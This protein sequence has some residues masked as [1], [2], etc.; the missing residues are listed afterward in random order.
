M[1]NLAYSI[2]VSKTVESKFENTKKLHA[3][4]LIK[5]EKI[6][7]KVNTYLF[8][9]P[10]RFFRPKWNAIIRQSCLGSSAGFCLPRA[11]TQYIKKL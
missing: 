8:T 2:G 9:A 6:G 3:V 7:S 1:Q 10:V 11:N 4:K 5:I